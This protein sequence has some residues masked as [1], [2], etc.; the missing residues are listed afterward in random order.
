MAKLWLI[1]ISALLLA[2]CATGSKSDSSADFNASKWDE[3]F[4]EQSQNYPRLIEL[5]KTQLK[6]KE[7]S[8]TRLKLAQ[9]YVD[10][11]D[12]ESALFTLTPLITST[13]ANAKTFYLQG[14][15]QYKLGMLPQ[16]LH[17]LEIAVKK[18]S[19]D[20]R[21]IN[22]L[23]V[24]QAELGQLS[25]ARGSFNKARELMYD[26]VAIKNNLALLDMI[27]GDF[28]QAAARLMPIY[29]NTPSKADAKVKANLAIIVSKLGSFETLKSLYAGKYSEAQ[30]FDI[31]HGLRASEP[32]TRTS[33]KA[34]TQPIRDESRVS[35]LHSVQPSSSHKQSALV[36]D[37][38]NAVASKK[39]E[40]KAVKP[41]ET[42]LTAESHSLTKEASHRVKAVAS[43]TMAYNT[44]PVLQK[45][46]INESTEHRIKP[47][48]GADFDMPKS[49][50]LS[51]QVGNP[52]I[53]LGAQKGFVD[54]EAER[55]NFSELT[56]IERRYDSNRVVTAPE[57]ENKRQQPKDELKT[58][59][60]VVT[61]ENN[62][63][64][65]V[66]VKRQYSSSKGLVSD[67]QLSQPS[68]LDVQSAKARSMGESAGESGKARIPDNTN[69]WDFVKLGRYSLKSERGLDIPVAQFRHHG[70]LIDITL[71]SEATVIAVE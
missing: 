5:Y 25:D 32:A 61:K 54:A 36:N 69:K 50:Y 8:D 1:S 38:A 49:V 20:A 57:L 68:V 35:S 70:N 56:G 55:T 30:L 24:A 11:G 48:N 39:N 4:L 15:A 51:E 13:H 17:S 28:K 12:N 42:V 58:N 66:G 16:A 45:S 41:L 71:D 53:P 26:D 9:V 43:E 40:P 47:S 67:Q 46:V 52:E 2:G 31:F 3:T 65:L 19:D 33:Q 63:A 62:F 18:S 34:I 22:M 23:G 27:E 7:S 59:A 6:Q 10:T 37:N 14:V 44:K 60:T 64:D 29:V 21:V